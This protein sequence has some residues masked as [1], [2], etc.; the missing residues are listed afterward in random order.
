MKQQ[1]VFITGATPK[2]NYKS[3]YQYLRE[4]IDYNPYE[5]QFLNWNKTLGKRLWEDYEYLRSPSCDLKFADYEA[6][7]IMFEKMFP[8]LR[9]DLILITTSLGSSFLL[10]YIGE[11]E[12]PLKIQ[13]L[14]F[15]APAIEDTPEEKLGSFYFDIEQVYTRVQRWAKK[16]YIYHSRDDDCVPFEQSLKFHSYFP[17][18]VF[19]DFYDKGHFYKE[20]ELPEIIEDIKS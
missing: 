12:F 14:F 19:R 5:E 1:V 9:K 15:V 16:I 7:K 2:E 18:A 4:K 8:Y 17:D 3:Y 20:A 13:K 10:K 11:N 6:W